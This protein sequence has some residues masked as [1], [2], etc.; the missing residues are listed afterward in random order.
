M[1]TLAW[2]WSLWSAGTTLF[3]GASFTI[4]GLV[5]VVIAYVG[6]WL[7]PYRPLV[8]FGGLALLVSGVWTS[9]VGSGQ[10]VSEERR[11]RTDLRIAEERIETQ[12]SIIEGDARRAQE[13]AD[14][15]NTLR[16]LLAQDTPAD[17]SIGLS[18]D[19][20]NRVRRFRSENR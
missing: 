1:Q 20:V 4:V 18:R 12:K 10:A 9:G 2:F 15:L 14:A 19:A 3:A 7:V 16:S 8:F 17:T 11:L 6:K 5:L 13:D